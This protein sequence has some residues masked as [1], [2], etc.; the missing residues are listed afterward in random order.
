MPEVARA[1]AGLRRIGGLSGKAE[2]TMKHHNTLPINGLHQSRRN[3]MFRQ[4]CKIY[5]V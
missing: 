1:F 3:L 2:T 5:G 4:V